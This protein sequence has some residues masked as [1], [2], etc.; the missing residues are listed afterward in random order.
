MRVEGI[1]METPHI[2][3]S[4]ESPEM[5]RK[6]NSNSS[7]SEGYEVTDSN[8]IQ[9][10]YT[11]T[12]TTY[13]EQQHIHDL[14]NSHDN[15]NF[16]QQPHQQCLVKGLKNT[17]HHQ[18]HKQQQHQKQQK[19]H[20]STY[21]VYQMDSN[22]NIINS[23]SQ[24]EDNNNNNN[25]SSADEDDHKLAERQLSVCSLSSVDFTSDYSD[26]DVDEPVEEIPNNKVSFYHQYI[27]KFFI[28]PLRG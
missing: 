22:S 4:K 23:S 21:H 14:H 28:F 2:I 17:L 13:S 3:I 11:T 26:N 25:S 18:H 5:T 8:N 6:Y 1:T 24:I 10:C 20:I 7:N 15:Q 16:R 19:P 9:C 27:D 12:T